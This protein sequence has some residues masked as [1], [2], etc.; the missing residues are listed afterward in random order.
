MAA[1]LL[2]EDREILAEST[3]VH[4][5]RDSFMHTILCFTCRDTLPDSDN[6]VKAVHPDD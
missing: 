3:P 4:L 2:I 5:A 6:R 1:Y